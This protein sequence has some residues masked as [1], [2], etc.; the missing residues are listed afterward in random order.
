MLIELFDIL[1]EF[2]TNLFPFNVNAPDPEL[3][4][5]PL[6]GVSIV[7]LLNGV[8]LVVPANWKLS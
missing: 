4:V 6:K 1:P 3:K 7:R 2:K 8:N 5:I